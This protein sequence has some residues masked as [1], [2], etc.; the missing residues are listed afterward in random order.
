MLTI[1][2]DDRSW[3]GVPKRVQRNVRELA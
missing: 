3:E 2:V 1:V